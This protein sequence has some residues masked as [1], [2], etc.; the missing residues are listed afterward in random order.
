LVVK[1]PI[2][3]RFAHLANGGLTGANLPATR[4]K[5]NSFQREP[6]IHPAKI[7][8]DNAGKIRPDVAVFHKNIV[9][10]LIESGDKH[11]QAVF[12]DLAIQTRHQF[13]SQLYPS[14]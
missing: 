9:R 1:T 14:R 3:N 5:E 7:F 6:R 12:G 4:A 8:R 10:T 13:V 11:S 2:E